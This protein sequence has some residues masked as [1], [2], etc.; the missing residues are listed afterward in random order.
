[1]IVLVLTPVGLHRTRFRDR[2]KGLLADKSAIFVQ[3][4]L[5]GAGLVMAGTTAF[6]FDI[7]IGHLAGIIVLALLLI[8]VTF[9]WFIY[10]RN[11]RPHGKDGTS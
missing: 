11:L 1:V 8:M 4:A 5:W 9:L 6:V 7:M 10:P 3:T 2:I